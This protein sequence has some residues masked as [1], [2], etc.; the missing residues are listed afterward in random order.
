[1]RPVLEADAAALG[2]VRRDPDDPDDPADPAALFDP[3]RVG[4]ES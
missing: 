2:S 1:M 4:G 3:R